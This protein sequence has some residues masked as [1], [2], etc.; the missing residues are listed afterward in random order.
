MGA[1]F[2]DTELSLN[3]LCCSFGVYENYR[4][5]S[6][7]LFKNRTDTFGESIFSAEIAQSKMK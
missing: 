1:T 6:L 7:N 2:S 5:R 3:R 4:N